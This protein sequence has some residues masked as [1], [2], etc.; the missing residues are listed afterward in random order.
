MTER[1]TSG[2]TPAPPPT[3]Q[4]AGVDLA[5]ADEAV[6]RIR[7]HVASTHRPGVLGGIGGFGGSFAFDQSRWRAPVLVSTTDGV[8]TKSEVARRLGRYDTIGI[9]C[10]AMS[11]DDLAACGAEP[12]FFLDYVSVGRNDPALVE[13]IVAGVAAGC[14][15]AGCA[16]VAG[17]IS[18]H[19]GLMEPGHFDLVGFAVGVAERDAML[20]R[21]VRPGDAVLGIASPGLRSNGY[22][23]AR[24][25]LLDHAGRRLEEPAWPGAEHSLG[26]E[27]LAPSVIYAPALG[28]LGAQFGQA[29]RAVAHVTG[30]GIGANLSRVLGDGTGAAL[31]RGSWPVPRIFAE[32]Q[33][34]GTVAEEEMARVFNLGLGMLVVVDP[35][36]SELALADLGV[37]G[38]EA[39]LVGEVTSGSGVS[40]G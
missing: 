24:A 7:A 13:A 30:G 15:R 38:H 16:L 28:R 12:L 37:S 34:A 10:V 35:G 19:P 32:I 27:L 20:P 36:A 2:D 21:S 5:A 31:T 29:V 18:E 33:A 11:V 1:V 4:A 6:E 23:L 39:Y 8:G 17:E 14:R 22:S 25:V 26:E 3:Y 40:V 9:D